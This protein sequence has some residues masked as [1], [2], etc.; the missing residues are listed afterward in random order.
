MSRVDTILELTRLR[1]SN[2]ISPEESNKLMNNLDENIDYT[3]LSNYYDDIVDWYSS[4]TQKKVYSTLRLISTQEV[5]S[6]ASIL[7]AY[8]SFLTQLFI[9]LEK[10]PKFPINLFYA[11]EVVQLIKSIIDTHSVD[12]SLSANLALNILTRLDKLG[13]SN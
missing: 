11:T 4:I 10:N 9:R 1:E 12:L 3:I 5:T 7:K 2:H 6:V 8:S 13:G